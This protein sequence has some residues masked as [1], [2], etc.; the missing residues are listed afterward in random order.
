M[1]TG[2]KVFAV[3]ALISA[4]TLGLRIYGGYA[5]ALVTRTAGKAKQNS[6]RVVFE[7]TQSY[8]QGKR[9]EASKLYKEWKLA[10]SL[11]DKRAIEEVVRIQF[12]NFDIDK[13]DGPV[14]TF[15]YN[16]LY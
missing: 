15:V 11:E 16:S 14:Y 10:D 2:L 3:F 7:Q 13:L 6:E 1:K 5:D 4:F 8:V 9:Q 12:S